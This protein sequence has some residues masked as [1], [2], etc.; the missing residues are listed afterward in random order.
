MWFLSSRRLSPIGKGGMMPLVEQGDD[1]LREKI[2]WLS[3]R[4]QSLRDRAEFLEWYGYD[5]SDERALMFELR[6]E[7]TGLKVR[8]SGL[9]E[10]R[11][12][13]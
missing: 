6:M 9:Q 5:A 13:A 8:L 7:I 1:S 12:E 4:W 3:F 2:L 10:A 11:E